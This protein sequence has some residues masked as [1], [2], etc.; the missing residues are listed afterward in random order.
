ML[1]GGNGDDTIE[2][3]IGND[4]LHGQGGNDRLLGGV[5]EDTLFGGNGD[6]T[7]KG[8]AGADKFFGDD[9]NDV[10][11]GGA[12]GDTM[13]GGAGVNTYKIDNLNDRVNGAAANSNDTLLVNVDNYKVLAGQQ[14]EHVEYGAGVKKLPS[15]IDQLY[16]GSYFSGQLT[17]EHSSNAPFRLRYTFAA[18]ATKNGDVSNYETALFNG[19]QKSDVR[20]ALAR[21]SATANVVFDEV[22]DTLDVKGQPSTALRFVISDSEPDLQKMYAM[23]KTLTRSDMP[24]LR[25]SFVYLKPG[26]DISPNAENGSGFHALLH[27]IG[28]SFGLQHTLAADD[29]VD[30]PAALA[31][32][33][34]IYGGTS[35]LARSESVMERYVSNAANAE[36]GIFDEAALHYQFGVSRGY[37]A[38]DQTYVLANRYIGDGSGVDTLS[39]ADQ[40]KGVTIDLAPGSW[41]YVGRSEPPDNLKIL[42]EGVAFIGFGTEI[43]NAVGGSGFEALIGNHRRRR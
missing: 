5:R 27:E 36:L 33:L 41:S 20:A 9:G 30:A 39:A 3:G 34:Q 31:E 16:S 11:D 21:F 13:L 28:H 2:G 42:N 38:G 7:I 17:G 6:D 4:T 37:N 32:T 29:N 1:V 8:G 14:I 25:Q 22:A 19:A 43:E 26:T 40:T 35:K 15:F 18:Y 23:E 10:I 24:G 12:G